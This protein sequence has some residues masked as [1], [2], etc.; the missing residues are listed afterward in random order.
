MKLSFSGV[1]PKETPE[2]IQSDKQPIILI[3]QLSGI[4][5][6]SPLEPNYYISIIKFYKKVLLTAQLCQ[7]NGFHYVTI[8]ETK[9]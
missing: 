8:H 5:L 6:F 2:E 1:V 3:T 7:Y 4:M 9:A